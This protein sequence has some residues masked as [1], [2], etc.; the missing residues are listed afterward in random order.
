MRIKLT[1]QDPDTQQ[2]KET[3][4]NTPVAIGC[5]TDYIPDD[6]DSLIIDNLSIFSCHAIIKEERGQP[7][8]R[9]HHNNKEVKVT[10]NCFTLGTVKIT[11]EVLQD[12]S[13]RCQKMVGFLFKKK[14]N[15]ISTHNCPYC[16]H[17]NDEYQSDYDYYEDYGSYNRWGRRYYRDRVYYRYDCDNRNVEFT[18]AD[19][20]AFQ[21]EYD[22][23]FEQNFSAS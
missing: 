10:N 2:Q 4:V 21:E 15:R 3:S 9:I 17:P 5:D 20:V 19:N 12:T 8:V 13:G 6:M 11:L 18:E 22:S 16:N 23:D 1:Y 7:K 14:C